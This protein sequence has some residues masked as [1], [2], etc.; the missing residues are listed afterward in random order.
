MLP[1]EGKRKKLSAFVKNDRQDFLFHFCLNFRSNTSGFSIIS[2][3]PD[4][5]PFRLISSIVL[6][7]FSSL[8]SPFLIAAAAAAAAAAVQFSFPPSSEMSRVDDSSLP[9]PLS[10]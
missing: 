10:F 7:L 3:P 2:P 8:I 9:L 4:F 1:N 6:E 5:L